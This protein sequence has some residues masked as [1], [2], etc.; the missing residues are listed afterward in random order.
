MRN[1]CHRPATADLVQRD[2]VIVYSSS[3]SP[4]F[5]LGG[6]FSAEQA[7]DIADYCGAHLLSA[8]E[9]VDLVTGGSC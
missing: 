7:D 1:A 9:F 3:S 6:G 4:V 5:H 8:A 2:R